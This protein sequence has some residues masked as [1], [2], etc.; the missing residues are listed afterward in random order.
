ML[1]LAGGCPE[2]GGSTA[3]LSAGRAWPAVTPE[4]P[5][6][7]FC[8]LLGGV[9]F[10]AMKSA[11]EAS[12]LMSLSS[13]LSDSSLLSARGQRRGHQDWRPLSQPSA[14]SQIRGSEGPTHLSSAS[15][16]AAWAP[17]S[18]PPPPCPPRAP[19]PPRS[20]HCSH[21][22]RP[23]PWDPPPAGWPWACPPAHPGSCCKTESGQRVSERVRRPAQG[24]TP[25]SRLPHL[26]PSDM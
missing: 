23:R 15:S 7:G 21:F 9:F 12:L 22:A 2:G 24:L 3:H 5:P 26:E 4:L 14:L 25:A 10:F 18:P 8:S 17:S 1:Q 16:P 11:E 19:F 13:E 20:L 6:D